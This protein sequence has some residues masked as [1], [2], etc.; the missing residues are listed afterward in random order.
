VI[1]LT[2]AAEVIALEDWSER[3]VL[4]ARSSSIACGTCSRSGRKVYGECH[5]AIATTADAGG[6]RTAGDSDRDPR[7][8]RGPL[9]TRSYAV[10]LGTALRRC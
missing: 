9:G 8:D 4:G 1:T 10:E 2:A 6:D 5:G 7:R 3:P